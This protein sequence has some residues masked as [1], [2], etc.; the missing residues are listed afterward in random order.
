MI[1]MKNFCFQNGL[2]LKIDVKNRFW[3]FCRCNYFVDP[4]YRHNY[5]YRAVFIL[6]CLWTDYVNKSILYSWVNQKKVWQWP[7]H[8]V[9]EGED[10]SR[11]KN[12]QQHFDL[13]AA[14]YFRIKLEFTICPRMTQEHRYL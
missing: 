2:V 1:G 8:Y 5:N 7:N 10:F 3:T 6:Q 9:E 13:R 14:G 11:H 12:V 4:S